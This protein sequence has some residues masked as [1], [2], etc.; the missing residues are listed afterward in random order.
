MIQQVSDSELKLMKII[1]EDGGAALYARIMDVRKN[2]ENIDK[3]IRLLLYCL[4]W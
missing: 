4:D 1:W 2:Q 3:K